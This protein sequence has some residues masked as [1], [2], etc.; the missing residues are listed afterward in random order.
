MI[1]R[2]TSMSVFVRVANKGSFAAAAEGL[3]LTPAMVGRHVRYLEDWVGAALLNRTTRRQ[4]LTELGQLF[5]ERAQNILTEVELTEGM[6]DS[7]RVLPSGTLRVTAP[8]SF[9][10]VLAPALVD[11][12]LLYP[13]VTIDLNLSDSLVD[14]PGEGFD[15]A[16]RTGPLA[17]SG[18]ISRS[19]APYRFLLC[20]APS[21]LAKFPAP[22]EPEDLQQHRCLAFSG[23]MDGVDWTFLRADGVER[24]VRIQSQIRIN[25]RVAM[26]AAAMAGGGIVMQPMASLALAVEEGSLVRLLPE[27]APP[28]K[29]LHLVWAQ[30]RHITQKLRTFIDFAV[31]R[32]GE[33]ESV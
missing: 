7:A 22:K 31:A 24:H 16:I 6:L 2:F 1:D 33:Q 11:Y 32:F 20:A 17:D 15:I 4:S 3:G 10:E 14:V 26:R 12:S 9:G 29:Q 19:L 13:K 25:N 23:W 18:L 5:L 21:Y 30:N 8:I 28:S 27:W